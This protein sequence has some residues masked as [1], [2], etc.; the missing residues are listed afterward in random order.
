[1]ILYE[2]LSITLGSKS[3]ARTDPLIQPT[4]VSLQSSSEQRQA[5]L[6]GQPQSSRASLHMDSN[7]D[8]H[9]RAR[10]SLVEILLLSDG[11]LCGRCNWIRERQWRCSP[12]RELISYNWALGIFVG[13][14]Q[15]REPQHIISYSLVQKA[16]VRSAQ[17]GAKRRKRAD[18]R[19]D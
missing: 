10:A 9:A 14:K 3:L 15:V 6:G 12:F 2:W 11:G 4:R 17:P 16:G 5:C 7:M 19:N 8:T 13:T 1:M 18:R